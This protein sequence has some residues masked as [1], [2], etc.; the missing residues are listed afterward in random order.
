[1]KHNGILS[2][3]G[4]IVCDD[5]QLK[6]QE[7]FTETNITKIARF[8]CRRNIAG[9]AVFLGRRPSRGA[10]APFAPPMD[11]PLNRT[12]PDLAIELTIYELKRGFFCGAYIEKGTRSF[13][14]EK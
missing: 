10:I 6:L 12:L 8:V 7:C 14:G 4:G 3:C 13:V 5:K 2:A 9:V 1:L 11:P